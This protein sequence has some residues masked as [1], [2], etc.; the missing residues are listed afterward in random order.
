MTLKRID[1][2]NASNGD[3]REHAVSPDDENRTLCGL[4][5][6]DM[7]TQNA[8]EIGGNR[9]CKRCT[10]LET[11]LASK[12]ALLERFTSTEDGIGSYAPSAIA[13]ARK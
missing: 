6:E 13:A 10:L 9:K 3:I 8:I 5:L 7:L 11:R 4:A 2:I 1:R 12:A